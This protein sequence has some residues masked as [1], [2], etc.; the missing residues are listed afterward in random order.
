MVAV[1]WDGATKSYAIK[2]EGDWVEAMTKYNGKQLP[3]DDRHADKPVIP[4]DALASTSYRRFVIGDDIAGTMSGYFIVPDNAVNF[5]EV[6]RGVI[7]Q[8][9]VRAYF[10]VHKPAADGSLVCPPLLIV[11]PRLKNGQEMLGGFEPYVA[12]MW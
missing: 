9:T 1:G 11:A 8:Q 12:N 5:F 4:L 6:N 3:R 7:S 10:A 2:R